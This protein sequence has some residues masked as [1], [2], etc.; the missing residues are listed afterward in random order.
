MKIKRACN[1]SDIE[2]AL[3]SVE[4]DGELELWSQNILNLSVMQKLFLHL[5]KIIQFS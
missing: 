5:I 4:E 3:A 1:L 2:L